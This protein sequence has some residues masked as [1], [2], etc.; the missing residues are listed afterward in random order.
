MA[1]KILAAIEKGRHE[2]LMPRLVNLLS[3]ARV[4]P[5][6]WFDKLM[7]QFGVNNTMDHFVG[8]ATTRNRSDVP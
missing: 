1:Q 6:R 5:V 3:P 8:R 4:L 2:L 7:N